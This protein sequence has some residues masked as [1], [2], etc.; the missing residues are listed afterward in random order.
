MIKYT[1]MNP[2]LIFAL[3]NSYRTPQLHVGYKM[4]E[5]HPESVNSLMETKNIKFIE[6]V[7]ISFCI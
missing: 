5:G 1:E 6:S 2:K 4:Y 3:R 7:I